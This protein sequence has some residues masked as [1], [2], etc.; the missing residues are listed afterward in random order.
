MPENH[1]PVQSLQTRMI[2]IRNTLDLIVAVPRRRRIGRPRWITSPN[3]VPRHT[4]TIVTENYTASQRFLREV[5]SSSGDGEMASTRFSDGGEFGLGAEIGISTNKLHARGPVGLEGLTTQKFIVVRA[6]GKSERSFYYRICVA[7]PIGRASP[8]AAFNENRKQ[9]TYTARTTQRI[10]WE[11]FNPMRLA[12]TLA[13]PSLFD[14][15]FTPGMGP[16]IRLVFL[17]MTS[18]CFAVG[19]TSPFERG[20][21]DTATSFVLIYPSPA[22]EASTPLK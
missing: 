10:R 8:R 18:S 14:T 3:T 22:R 21:M 17:T 4:E 15:F 11:I 5:D 7:K 2:G 6:G 1:S 13:L 12:G 20:F 19:A 9:Q 16:Q